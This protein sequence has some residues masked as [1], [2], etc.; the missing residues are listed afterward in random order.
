MSSSSHI[1]HDSSSEAVAKLRDYGTG[2]MWLVKSTLVSIQARYLPDDDMPEENLYVRA[3]AVGGPFLEGNTL[4]VG[5]LSKAV[6]WNGN[7]ILASQTSS[8]EV[9]GLIHAKR[10][11]NSSLVEDMSVRI[12]GIDVEFPLGVTLTVNRQ[13]KHIN[14]HVAMPPLA[15]GQEGLCGNYNGDADDDTLELIM[16]NREPKVNSLDSLFPDRMD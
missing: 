4:I 6:L 3:V 8:F 12:P 1:N 11:L 15:G 5:P 7:E 10:H 13:Q 16:Q 9:D 2:D 14:V